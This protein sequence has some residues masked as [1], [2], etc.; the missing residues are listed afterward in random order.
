[1]TILASAL[2]PHTRGGGGV[3]HRVSLHVSYSKSG[4]LIAFWI[5]FHGQRLLVGHEASYGS[6]YTKY[7]GLA[8]NFVSLKIS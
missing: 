8:L 2:P 1:M 3:E 5:N 6:L 7:V 4:R